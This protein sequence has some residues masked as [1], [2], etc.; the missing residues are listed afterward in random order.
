[1]ISYSD[2]ESA[3]TK[4]LLNSYCKYCM[5]L[6]ELFIAL[7]AVY[8]T[9][10]DRWRPPSAAPLYDRHHPMFCPVPSLFLSLSAIE[11]IKIPSSMH[12]NEYKYCM[13]IN[14]RIFVIFC[15]FRILFQLDKLI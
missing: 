13:K 5:A 14:I 6:L 9:R 4:T 1:M 10:S 11:N 3:Q 8:S 2:S 15:D 12:E 7:L